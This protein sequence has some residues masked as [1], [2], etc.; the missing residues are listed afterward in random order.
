[1]HTTQKSVFAS[2]DLEMA[3]TKHD[4]YISDLHLS[5]LIVK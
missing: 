1:M 3:D 5:A 2:Y 4:V